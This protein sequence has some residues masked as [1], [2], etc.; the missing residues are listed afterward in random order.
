MTP[1]ALFS[2]MAALVMAYAPIRKMAS[3]SGSLQ[4]AV[5]ATDRIFEMLDREIEISCKEV[6]VPLIGVSESLAFCNVTF[7]YEKS[8]RP[9]LQDIAFSI[10]AG[11]M[12]ALVGQSGS[13]KSTLA[14]LIP[15]LYEPTS[16][17]IV[18]DG[19]D[20][21]KFTLRSLRRQIAFVPQETVLFDDSVRS[22]V[23]Y[24]RVEATD[25]EIMGALQ[26]AYAWEFVQA[27]PQGLDTVI[28]EKGVK[29]SGGQRQRLA[30]ARAILRDAPLLILDEATSSLD[31]ESEAMVQRALANLLSNRTT[32]VIAHRLSTVLRADCILVLH[33]GRV[34]GRGTHDELLAGCEA[35]QRLYQAQFKDELMV[36]HAE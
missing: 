1:G 22:N 35:Y 32:I 18:I 19:G 23:A 3:S 12:V 36:P 24:G 17:T 34:A 27:L 13:G 5:V 7:R 16:G 21:R 30:I 10:K 4:E 20:I 14:H 28:G 33:Q 15:R 6:G 2:F 25:Q 8:S 26:A 11:E 31:S 29:L 9:A